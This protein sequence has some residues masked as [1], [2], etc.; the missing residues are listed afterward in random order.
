[1]KEMLF[2]LP[3]SELHIHC[4]LADVDTQ[5]QRASDHEVTCPINGER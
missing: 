1:M 4:L 3:H 2:L 5:R